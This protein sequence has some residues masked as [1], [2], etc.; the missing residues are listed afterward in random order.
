MLF[1]LSEDV[2]TAFKFGNIIHSPFIVAKRKISRETNGFVLKVWYSNGLFGSNDVLL[3]WFD[4][5]KHFKILKS[6]RDNSYVLIYSGS[7][8]R[9][10][11]KIKSQSN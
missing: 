8:S 6:K 9:N 4:A 7:F 10:F 1:R 5:L 11:K 2:L 3:S